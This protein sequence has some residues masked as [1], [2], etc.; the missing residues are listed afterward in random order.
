MKLIFTFAKRVPFTL[1]CFFLLFFI[2]FGWFQSSRYSERHLVY[3]GGGTIEIFSAS[4]LMRLSLVPGR[5][6]DFGGKTFYRQKNSRG[7][8]MF[9]PM[10]PKFAYR[11]G[12]LESTIGYWHLGF[13]CLVA[14]IL[15]GSWEVG[16]VKRAQIKGAVCN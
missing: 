16:R 10:Y 6:G 9:R 11:S 7:R 13:V 3:V 15:V 4:S 1:L 8:M 12:I 5:V 2:V 14:L